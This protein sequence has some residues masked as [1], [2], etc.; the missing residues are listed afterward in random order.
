MIAV[1]VSLFNRWVLLLRRVVLINWRRSRPDTLLI[2]I[3][4]LLLRGDGKRMRGL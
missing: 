4:L 2:S 1:I 3:G